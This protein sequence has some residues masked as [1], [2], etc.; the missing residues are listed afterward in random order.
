M[1]ATE[2]V[3]FYIL[4]SLD[5]V[6]GFRKLVSL[7]FLADYERVGSTVIKYLYGGKPLSRA[8]FYIWTYGPMS[9]EVYRVI[10]SSLVEARPDESGRVVLYARAEPRLPAE[11]RVRLMEVL[12]KY[13]ELRGGRLERLAL[14]LLRL[15]PEDKA[16]FM[17]MWVDDY[18]REAGF[19]LKLVDFTAAPVP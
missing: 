4:R 18:L 11:V 1:Y 15:R 16:D 14:R 13:G 10:G 6:Y 9:N 8:K 3:V 5:G 2:D 12:A 17:G 7:V 19:R